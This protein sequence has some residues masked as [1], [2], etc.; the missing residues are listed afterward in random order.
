M[1]VT[2]NSDGV[3]VSFIDVTRDKCDNFTYRAELEGAARSLNSQT[4]TRGNVF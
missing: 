1:Q 3:E 4:V 2:E